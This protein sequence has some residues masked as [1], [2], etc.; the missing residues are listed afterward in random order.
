MLDFRFYN[1][2]WLARLSENATLPMFIAGISLLLPKN[3]GE[4]TKPNFGRASKEMGMQRE[5]VVL[6]MLRAAAKNIA[7]VERKTPPLE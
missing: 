1:S 3:A 7:D 6:A 5:D 2:V 4:R